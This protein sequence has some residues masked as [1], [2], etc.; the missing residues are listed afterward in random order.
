MSWRGSELPSKAQIEAQLP[1]CR[2]TQ[3]GDYENCFY[4]TFVDLPGHFPPESSFKLTLEHYAF[5]YVKV[6]IS[7]K[8]E[9]VYF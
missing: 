6:D 1:G 7:Y 8:A 3:E 2:L 9:E 4:G 5:A